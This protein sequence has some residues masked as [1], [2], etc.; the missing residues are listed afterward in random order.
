M[1]VRP[2]MPCVDD[3]PNAVARIERQEHARIVDD[4]DQAADGQRDEPD[5]A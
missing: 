1:T 4:V 2:I 3:E 5:D